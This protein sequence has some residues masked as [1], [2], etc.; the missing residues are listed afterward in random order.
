MVSV[1][2][3]GKK[4]EVHENGRTVGSYDTS[5]EAW[6]YADKLTGEAMNKKQDTSEWSFTQWIKQ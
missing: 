6:R 5:R 2:I 4:H 3:S 1:T